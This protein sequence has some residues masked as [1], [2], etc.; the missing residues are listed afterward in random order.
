MFARSLLGASFFLVS[1]LLCAQHPE[2]PTTEQSEQPTLQVLQPMTQQ[3]AHPSTQAQPHPGTQQQE[4]P[5][6][7]TARQALL[8]ILTGGEDAVARHL[9]VEVQQSMRNPASQKSSAMAFGTIAGFRNFSLNGPDQKTFDTGPVLIAVDDPKTHER[10]EAHVDNDDLNG[11][12]DT[13]Q[14]SLHAFRDG[15]EIDSA[16]QIISQIEV[17]M[18]K[19]Q[20]IWRVNQITVS[21]SL[22]V[23]DPKLMEQLTNSLEN[24]SGGMSGFHITSGKAAGVAEKPKQ[25]AQRTLQMLAFG[26]SIYAGAHPETGFTCSLSELAAQAKPLG[27]DPAVATGP[28]NGYRFAVS[29]CQGTPAASYQLTAEPAMAAPGAKAF[30]TDA[31]HNVRTSEDGRAATC[32]ISGKPVARGMVQVN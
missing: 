26:E 5:R 28:F 15:Q 1:I 12:E 23:G 11:E 10:I 19:Q 21:A 9:T 8:E 30:C 17:G 7:Q 4:R 6:L 16:L 27:I 13:M 29:N 14:L 18:K 31:T 22:P 32:L 24:V 3:Q 25:D 20:N 2:Q